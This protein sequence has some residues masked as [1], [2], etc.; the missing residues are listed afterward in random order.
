MDS[1]KSINIYKDI[2]KEKNKI[3]KEKQYVIEEFEKQLNVLSNIVSTYKNTIVNYDKE[4]T[5]LQ[6][7][8]DKL[9]K[10]KENYKELYEQQKTTIM[11]IKDDIKACKYDFENKYDLDIA[12]G[13]RL[14]LI[15]TNYR[16]AEAL[17]MIES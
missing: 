5:D 4:N 8:L 11:C 16:L 1:N 14:K 10:E 17:S 2:I 12:N 7:K 9:D 3:I 6:D 15:V 13:L